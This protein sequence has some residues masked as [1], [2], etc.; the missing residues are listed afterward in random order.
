MTP[1]TN[2]A[3]Q[4]HLIVREPLI[5]SQALATEIAAYNTTPKTY[6]DS[7][8][9]ALGV[10]QIVRNTLNGYRVGEKKDILTSEALARTERADCYGQTIVFS[11]CLDQAQIE[12][13]IC[14]ANGHAFPLIGE[15]GK[16]RFTMIDHMA[17]KFNGDVT[18]A[19]SGTDV[20]GQLS[21]GKKSALVRF[22]TAK[23]LQL[24]GLTA[25]IGKVA[26]SNDWLNHD[27]SSVS[28]VTSRSTDRQLLYM[29]VMPPAL[30]RQTLLHYANAITHINGGNSAAA[31][32]EIQA[33][34]LY[35]DV[36]P[37]NQL[38]VAR[39]ARTLAFEQRRWGSAL[40]AADMIDRSVDDLGFLYAQYF[41]PDTYRKIGSLTG[42][43]EMFGA[44]LEAYARVNPGS[45]LTREKL[46]K[47]KEQYE[48][49]L[50]Q[51]PKA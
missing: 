44:S 21:S 29:Q 33:L 9:V 17:H 5:G 14:F 24:R 46:R 20:Y 18:S 25:G 1:R 38:V 28:L 19:I 11:E 35:P 10:A 45:R 15:R 41:K 49:V 16:Q 6:E 26:V 42:I 30:G 32:D 43:G 37:R 34:P 36:D 50:T 31:V 8:T 7:V 4:T 12:H 2:I 51:A 39:N 3:E 13:F 23:M 48:R 22:D 27:A 40:A 47:T